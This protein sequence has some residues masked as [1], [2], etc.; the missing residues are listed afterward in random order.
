MIVRSMPC[1]A[2]GC[3][4]LKGHS[5]SVQGAQVRSFAEATLQKPDIPVHGIHGRYALALFEAGA[6]KGDLDKIDADLKQVTL[7]PYFAGTHL[8][9]SMMIKHDKPQNML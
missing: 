8:K 7:P 1:H 5:P 4:H 2:T 9:F 3:V 6:K